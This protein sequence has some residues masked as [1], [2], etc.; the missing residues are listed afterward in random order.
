MIVFFYCD[1][2]NKHI[3]TYFCTFTINTALKTM[4]CYKSYAFFKHQVKN[5]TIIYVFFALTNI[6][7]L[8]R[9]TSAL[10]NAT[11]HPGLRLRRQSLEIKND[12]VS[13]YIITDKSILDDDLL[14]SPKAVA[15]LLLVFGGLG[16][17]SIKART[18]SPNSKIYYNLRYSFLFF[19][20]LRI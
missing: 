12:A 8:P 13:F 19:C 1:S 15:I 17:F 4:S 18:I 2:G 20:K 11:I 10:A 14:N 9:Y 6:F 7:F 16:V 5:L 3:Y